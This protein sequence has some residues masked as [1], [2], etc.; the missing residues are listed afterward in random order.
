MRAIAAERRPVAIGERTVVL[1]QAFQGLPGEVEA[2]EGGITALQRGDDAQRLCVVIE[3]AEGGETFIER[4]LAGMAERRM[5]E[6]VRKRQRFGEIFVES[7]GAGERTRDLRHFKRVGEPGAVVVALV[8]YE[9]LS[10]V[11]EA[12]K[13]RRM[14]DAIAV[15]AKGAAA[16]ARGLRIEPAAAL[17]RIARIARAR[18]CGFDRHRPLGPLQLT[19]ALAALNYRVDTVAIAEHCGWR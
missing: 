5:A 17:P 7:Q 3:A 11:L 10:L 13:G 16:F 14:D 9:H 4:A 19:L 6:I 15:A 2:V 18:R 1:D 12:A 8:E